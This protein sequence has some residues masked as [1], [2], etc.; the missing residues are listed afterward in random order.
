[1]PSTTVPAGAKPGSFVPVDVGDDKSQLVAIPDGMRPG[2]AFDFLPAGTLTKTM[3]TKLPSGSKPGSFLNVP[4]DGREQLVA[5]PPGVGPNDAVRFLAPTRAE[6]FSYGFVSM[7][8]H[9]GQFVCDNK[10]ADRMLKG[11]Y[12]REEIA[13]IER[14]PDLADLSVLELGGCLAVLTCVTN[15][16][17]SRPARHVV[18]E[19][20][21]RLINYME[22]NKHLNNCSFAIEHGIL[23]KQAK[24]K[25]LEETTFFSYDNLV[26]G[27]AHRMDEREANKRAHQ[28]PVITLESV[29][30][31]TRSS[32]KDP[33]FNFDVVMLDIEGGEMEF[34]K[35]NLEYIASSVKYVLIEIHEFLMRQ[36]YQR[37]LVEMMEAQGFYPMGRDDITFLFGKGIPKPT[38]GGAAGGD[39]FIAYPNGQ[40]VSF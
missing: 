17:L 23:S 6:D 24:A 21:P 28:V 5:V 27:S 40:R 37:E 1:M 38:S 34:I 26:A 4:I 7:P 20:N 8:Y 39:R 12:E 18:V 13:M 36:G 29:L 30:E 14:I 25:G 32:L 35:D 3:E 16:K 10:M 31:K 19:A 9:N 22:L 11:T 2:Q 33:N 15:K